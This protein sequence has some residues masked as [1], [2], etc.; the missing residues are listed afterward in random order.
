MND[1]DR[2]RAWELF[3]LLFQAHPWH[4]VSIGPEAPRVVTAYI[5]IVPTDT[6]KYE[7]D[8]SSGHLKVDR[9][10]QFS[11]VCPTL[12]GFIP[13]TYCGERVAA[14]G[15]G[16]PGLAPRD[17]GGCRSPGHLHPFGEDLLARRHP[18]PG[19]AG[20]RA[21]P[22]RPQP[23]GRQDRRRAEGGC[24]VRPLPGD[25]RSARRADRAAPALLPHLQAAAR[26]G[27]D[28]HRHHQRLRLPP[29]P[30]R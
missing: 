21:A 13:Q 28:S 23:G 18:S 2:E 25:R 1:Q 7:I 9:P 6:V 27:A 16:G 17:R 5:E 8:K 30:T 19:G 15:H 24:G 4:G 26:S 3:G 22:D 10:Q 14:F 20:R 12:Y 29:R 11:N